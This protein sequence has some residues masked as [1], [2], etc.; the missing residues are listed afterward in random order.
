MGRH[1]FLQRIF[2]LQY[3]RHM[4]PAIVADA[5]FIEVDERH[6]PR[7]DAL[8]APSQFAGRPGKVIKA[9]MY[10]VGK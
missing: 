7:Q 9:A 2:A 8:R 4:I 3:K 1:E 10:V 6:R 5:I